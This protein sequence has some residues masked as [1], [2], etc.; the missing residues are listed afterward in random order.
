MLDNS[1]QVRYD[2][3][4]IATYAISE[5]PLSAAVPFMLT[6]HHS[7]FEVIAVASGQCVVTIDQVLYT[8]TA[9][10]LILIPPY[11][12][13]SGCM[14]PGDA[15]SHFCFC[16]DLQLLQ[17]PSLFKQFESGYLDV[18]RVLRH[19]D[20][21][22]EELFAAAL[23]VYR[24][25]QQR[26]HGW[27]LLVRG[28]LLYMMGLLEQQGQIFSTVHG[29][30]ARSDFSALTLDLLSRSY[31]SDLTSKDIAAQLSYSQSYFCRLFRENFSLSFQEY[32]CQYRLCKA[33]LLLA[34]N[35][36]SVSEVAA[37]VGFHNLSYFARQFR[38]LYGC[39]PK[40]F[41]TMQSGP[42]ETY[43]YYL[44]TAVQHAKGPAAPDTL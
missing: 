42:T 35:A 3:L 22:C 31:S 18:T 15:F 9:G 14:L 20:A 26:E 12:L 1:F 24:Q 27:E 40:Q 11:S 39:S 21:G 32:L 25:C 36:L 2:K 6:H 5:P 17:E 43:A 10:D 8:A 16:F 23:F 4:P 13:H 28:E 33:R 37:K 30:D 34:Q 41:Q 29:S 7:E 38:R 44:G 19:G